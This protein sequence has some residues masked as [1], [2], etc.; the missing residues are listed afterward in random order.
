VGHASDF[1]PQAFLKREGANECRMK[2]R[3][4]LQE[5]KLNLDAP[6]ASPWETSP[7][8]LSLCVPGDIFPV[9]PLT[10]SGRRGSPECVVGI[11]TTMSR[12]PEPWTTVEWK[13]FS[14]GDSEAWQRRSMLHLWVSTTAFFSLIFMA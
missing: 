3:G 6:L 7:L 13:I 9:P 14:L 12:N 10:E 1:L 11:G 2:G 8:L 4:A 5:R